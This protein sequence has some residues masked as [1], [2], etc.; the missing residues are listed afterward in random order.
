MLGFG[1]VF[2]LTRLT[3]GS[4]DV[5]TE[6]EAPLYPEFG[7]NGLMH[8]FASPT[9]EFLKQNYSGFFFRESGSVL[10]VAAA[11]LLVLRP[12]NAR[13]LRWEVCCVPIAALVLFAA[14]H[15]LLFRLYLPHRYMYPLLPF[16]CI[17]I[18]VWAR[19]TSRRRPARR[20]RRRAPRADRVSARAAALT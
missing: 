2:V 17:A 9:L 5:I 12:R 14:A 7:P 4:Q 3:T 19:P 13:L 16:F 20:P 10:A 1:A 15:A 18:A 8:F 11:L 6:A